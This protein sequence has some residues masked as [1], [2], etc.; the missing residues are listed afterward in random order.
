MCRQLALTVALLGVTLF[1]SSAADQPAPRK[2]YTV[3]VGEADE[4]LFVM[5]PGRC[6]TVDEQLELSAE[7]YEALKAE[8]ERTRTTKYDLSHPCK[9]RRG[10]LRVFGI[11][12]GERRWRVHVL[13]TTWTPYEHIESASGEPYPAS[14]LYRN[15]GSATPLWTVEW[16]AHQVFLSRNGRHLVR[17]GPWAR[18]LDDLAVGFYTDGVPTHTYRIRKLLSDQEAVVHTA[19]HFFWRR[20][21]EFD[22]TRDQL[23]LETISGDQYV[24]DADGGQIAESKKSRV[25]DIH[26]TVIVSDQSSVPLTKVRSCGP[27]IF[28]KMHRLEDGATDVPVIT[29]LRVDDP[30]ESDSSPDSATDSASVTSR[31]ITTLSYPFH[32]IRAVHHRGQVEEDHQ[33]RLT[34]ITGQTVILRFSADFFA[35]C[36]Q[37]GTGRK[38]RFAPG[39]F[40][41]VLIGGNSS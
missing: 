4:F 14:G 27:F 23:F 10:P 5:L 37:D 29:G 2:P 16:Y 8:E 38:R 25:R 13:R 22:E 20:S 18:I 36:G 26:A 3:T 9:G 40:Q 35:L 33:Y 39:E 21:L 34:F 28:N 41:A 15:D 24:F 19:S 31:S 7:E 11:G 6:E 1:G 17:M 12:H 32:L 30:L